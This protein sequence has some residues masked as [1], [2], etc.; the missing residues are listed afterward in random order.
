[1]NSQLKRLT[2]RSL[3]NGIRR[4]CR[5]LRRYGFG[6]SKFELVLFGFTG[7]VKEMGFIPT[8][9][10]TARVV[11]RHP[12]IFRKICNDG[13]ELAI[14]GFKHIDYTALTPE[15]IK[16]HIMMATSIFKKNNIE[17][18]GFRFPFLRW[19]EETLEIIRNM[20]FSYDSSE[21]VVW[22]VLEL[23]DF[24]RASRLNYY[25]ILD[26][27]NA[28]D[29]EKMVSLPIWKNG[30][31]EIPVA[32]PDDDILFDRLGIADEARVYSTFKMMIDGTLERGELIVLQLHPERYFLYK[33]A[34]KKILEFI[35]NRN[36]IYCCS[37]NQI[38]EWWRERRRFRFEI[39][40][41]GDGLFRVKAHCSK[42]A[43]I[44]VNNSNDGSRTIFFGSYSIVDAREWTMRSSVRPAVAISRW[45]S[46]GV[47]DF[48][49]SE[50][51]AYKISKTRGDCALFLDIRHDIKENDK[52]SI[53]K[54]IDDSGLPVLRFWRW[55]YKKRGCVAITGDVDS[56]DIWDFGE[57]FYG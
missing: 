12:N 41:K 25:K 18:S 35:S 11:E 5:I 21:T 15:E 48:I 13:V 2:T 20:G 36:D 29:F 42:R 43:T 3:S 8:I 34:L 6:S 27:Y 40:G 53:L 46:R 39:E 37:M 32:I 54:M 19:N 30:I 16:S 7:M 56:V 38:S 14:H 55:P 31:V 4:F 17:F 33:N 22:N 51:F 1:M 23:N 24:G 26:T 52:R 49:R 28:S 10:V 47:K 57:R 45:S 50:G 44:L 9:P